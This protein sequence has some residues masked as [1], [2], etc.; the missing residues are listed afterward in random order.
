MKQSILWLLVLFLQGSFV[1]ASIPPPDAWIP[2]DEETAAAINI[3]GS[4][5]AKIRTADDVEL[6]VLHLEATNHIC[7]LLATDNANVSAFVLDFLWEYREV[8]DLSELDQCSEVD[9]LPPKLGQILDNLQDRSE[10][11]F[12]EQ[13]NKRDVLVSC[14]ENGSIELWRG[15]VLL[16]TDCVASAVWD[17]VSGLETYIK[18]AYRQSFPQ[19]VQEVVSLESLLKIYEF[20]AGEGDAWECRERAIER[21]LAIGTD[22]GPR[23]EADASFRSFVLDLG[24]KQCL[25]GR[26]KPCERFRAFIAPLWPSEDGGTP[27][28]LPFRKHR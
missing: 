16:A 20:T 12:L 18:T 11:F 6:P 14:L 4:D 1:A 23:L 26:E 22:L 10:L 13:R 15:T 17:G 21:I 2:T 19:P 5:F 3:V 24:K 7:E 25:Y 9:R 8:M 27:A 28:E